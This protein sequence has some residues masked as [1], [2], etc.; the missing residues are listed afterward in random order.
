[1]LT[2][3]SRRST[4][5]AM[6]RL[7]ILAVLLLVAGCASDPYPLLSGGTGTAWTS[8]GRPVRTVALFLQPR[9]GDRV[10][11]L[12]AEPIGSLA[13]ADV[14]FFFF[15]PPVVSADGTRTIGETLEP[16]SGASF[17][18]APGAAPGPDN[19]VGI[20]VELTPRVAGV[21][22][23][24]SVRLHLRLNSGS[25]EVKAESLSFTVCAPDPAPTFCV[26]PSSP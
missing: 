7:F 26:V 11:L 2:L 5:G 12:S 8:V 20:V 6:N 17:A 24:T 9:P 25:E 1:M 14:A 21:F 16:R 19:T 15:S 23:L 13:G 10:K 18:A 22:E 3:Q 4:L